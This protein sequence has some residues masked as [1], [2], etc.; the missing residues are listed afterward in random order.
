MGMAM[1]VWFKRG[2]PKSL[3]QMVREWAEENSNRLGI[4]R[5]AEGCEWTNLGLSWFE[6]AKATAS[7]RRM[8][9]P[10]LGAKEIRYSTSPF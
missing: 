5:K 6:P 8:V 2:S 9:S 1:D 10:Y 7:T 3:R 4:H